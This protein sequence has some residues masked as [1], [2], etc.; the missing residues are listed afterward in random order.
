MTIIVAVKSRTVMNEVKMT[1]EDAL[2]RFKAAKQRKEECVAR[3]KME[4][5]ADYEK[6]TGKKPDSIFVL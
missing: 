4:L 2:R 5:I 1:R 3:L 6:R